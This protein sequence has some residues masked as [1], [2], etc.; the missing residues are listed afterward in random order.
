[1]TAP[2]IVKTLVK[3]RSPGSGTGSAIRVRLPGPLSPHI[4][5]VDR[6]IARVFGVR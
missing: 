1:M 6:G 5:P 2:E 4:L 3:S